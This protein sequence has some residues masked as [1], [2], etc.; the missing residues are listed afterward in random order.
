MIM[1]FV[2]DDVIL[3]QCFCSPQDI[4]NLRN[5]DILSGTP[6]ALS[7]SGRRFIS[8]GYFEDLRFFKKNVK[9]YY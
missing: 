1:I 4:P 6:D 9:I 2:E 7:Q 3:F 8:F 5:L